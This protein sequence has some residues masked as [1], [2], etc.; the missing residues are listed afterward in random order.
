MEGEKKEDKNEI[1]LFLENYMTLAVVLDVLF[2]LMKSIFW[3]L[4]LTQI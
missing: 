3:Y 4:K 2:I 1:D